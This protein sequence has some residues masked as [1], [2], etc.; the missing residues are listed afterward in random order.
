MNDIPSSGNDAVAA[1]PFSHAHKDTRCGV[2]AVIGAP[3]VGKSTLVNALVG[4]K[5]SI[6]THKV[7]T[8]RARVRGVLTEA[9]DQFIFI[10]TPGIFAPRR[11]LDRAMVAAAW[12]GLSGADAVLVIV[13]AAAMIAANGE[14]PTGAALKSAKDTNKII[15]GLQDINEKNILVINKIDRVPR[16]ELLGLIDRLNENKRFR[17]TLLVSAENGDGLP[18]LKETIAARLPNGPWLYPEDQLSDISDRLL[19]AEITREK[20]Y[21][22]LHDELPYQLTVETQSWTRNEKG[23]L[24]VDQIIYVSRDSHK[25]IVIGKAGATLKAIGTAARTELMEQLG[26]TVHLAIHVSVR[27]NWADERARYREIGLDIVD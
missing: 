8:T 11:R 20:L 4:A 23:D 3:N 17:E 25:P 18:V 15:E 13:D 14:S 19:A 26:C 6:V 7:Q 5:V 16:I 22:R 24:R 10:D 21:L 1:N 12:E 9:A 27:Q 2:I